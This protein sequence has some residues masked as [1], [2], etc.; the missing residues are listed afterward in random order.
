MQTHYTA[1]IHTVRTIETSSDPKLILEFDGKLSAKSKRAIKSA[2]ER[3]E[4]H[5]REKV[6]T[7]A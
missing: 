6:R 2:I 1:E 4:V 7:I 3:G 5:I